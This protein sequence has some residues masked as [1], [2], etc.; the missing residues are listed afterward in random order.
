MD[1]TPLWAIA[2][3]LIAWFLYL[4][5]LEVRNQH[6]WWH[7]PCVTPAS[8]RDDI[9]TVLS[10]LRRA[11][12]GKGITWW[13]DYGTLLGAWRIGDVM[14]FDHDLDVSFLAEHEERLLACQDELA[15][16]GIE[17]RMANTSLWFRGAKIGDIE[18]WHRVGDMLYRSDPAS[19]TV[20]IR[21]LTSRVDDFPASWVEPTWQ[22]RFAGEFYPCPNHPDRF[23]RRRY[24][25]ARIHLRFV[26]P[27]KQRCWW[28]PD[29]WKAAWRIWTCRDAPFI[30]RP[31]A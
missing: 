8:T 16:Q 17:L 5:Y 6:H 30:R 31:E 15:A 9:R 7:A 29:F 4:L 28:N 18:R 11:L 12:E 19:R 26:I 22:I 24:L 10:A 23:L 2:A 14:P 3:L 20:L 25:G 21:A 27:H 13:L 1:W